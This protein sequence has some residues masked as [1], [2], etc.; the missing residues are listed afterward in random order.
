MNR[1]ITE[2]KRILEAFPRVT[3]DEISSSEIRITYDVAIAKKEKI[4]EIADAVD[5][6]Y[7][8]ISYLSSAVANGVIIYFF[9]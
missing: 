1:T 5:A 7:W 4:Q 3:V 6:K 2:R 8:G 9:F